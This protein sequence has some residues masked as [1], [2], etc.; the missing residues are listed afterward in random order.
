MYTFKIRRPNTTQYGLY[1]TTEECMR[2]LLAVHDVCE[3][4][5]IAEILDQHGKILHQ[6][7]KETPSSLLN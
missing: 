3:F 4:G 5:T 7:V 1:P 6:F 2:C